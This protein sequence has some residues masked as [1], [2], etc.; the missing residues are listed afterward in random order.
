VI[1][2]S[3]T[4]AQKIVTFIRVNKYYLEALKKSTQ[5]ASKDGQRPE[6]TRYPRSMQRKVLKE[7]TIGWT[8]DIT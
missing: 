7:L 5:D 2:Y 3:D 6:W 8:L 4:S 1:P